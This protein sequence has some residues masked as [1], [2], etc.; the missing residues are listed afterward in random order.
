LVGL[1]LLQ[2]LQNTADQVLHSESLS[3]PLDST[4]PRL[5][6]QSLADRVYWNSTRLGELMQGH[7]DPISAMRLATNLL[8]AASSIA[9]LRQE[10]HHADVVQELVGLA[11]QQTR[12][13]D[14]QRTAQGL[15]GE[16]LERGLDLLLN[17]SVDTPVPR[18]TQAALAQGFKHLTTTEQKLQ[19][20]RLVGNLL[21]VAPQVPG[22]QSAD[23]GLIAMATAYLALKPTGT[24]AADDPLKFLETLTQARTPQVIQQGV[25]QLQAFL[26]GAATEP[27]RQRLMQMGVKTLLAAKQVQLTSDLPELRQQMSDV[28]MLN[29][30]VGLARAYAA[31]DPALTT[32]DLNDLFLNTLYYTQNTQ[33][34]AEELQ[35]FFENFG[36]AQDRLNL[37]Q[38]QQKMFETFKFVGE[39][40][41]ALKER[42]RDGR[43]LHELA[44]GGASFLDLQDALDKE[45]AI[46]DEWSYF[47]F[48]VWEAQNLSDKQAASATFQY[49]LASE[50]WNS[51]YVDPKTKGLFSTVPYDDTVLQIV[52]EYNSMLL[53][54][55]PRVAKLTRPLDWILV[56]AMIETETSPGT[57]A[58]RYDP[59]QVA[60]QGDQA[61]DTI[62]SGGES[63]SLITSLDLREDLIDV[64]KTP[65]DSSGAPDYSNYIYL[66]ANETMT[67]ERSIKI[68]VPW[69]I[70]KAYYTD[71]AGSIVSWGSWENAVKD[72]NG[73]GDPNYW[74]KVKN[75]YEQLL[76][77]NHSNTYRN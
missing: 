71:S 64:R 27:E 8:K 9:E 56:G 7:P 2:R 3:F 75:A 22:M 60:N 65:F 13:N 30:L 40:D 77:E 73:G 54:G 5:V 46:V 12:F 10:L 68:G 11:F 37:V 15:S 57:P 26:A 29:Q 38:F 63:T 45:E 62:R 16:T 72:Y 20:I 21:E 55:K 41:L 39:S 34:G 50:Q 74:S 35:A 70:R 69:L 58:R 31:L 4:A 61:L 43:F 19:L 24:M 44:D 17:Q 47:C 23:S 76:R 28:A 42:L 18:A 51:R 6:V 36:T 25:T 59:M 1:F 66:L 49:T 14:P 67:S 52:S 53:K 32:L 33:K 48:K